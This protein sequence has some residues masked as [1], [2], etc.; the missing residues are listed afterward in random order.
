MEGERLAR[1]SANSY[2]FQPTSKPA[3]GRAVRTVYGTAHELRGAFG[4]VTAR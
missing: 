3:A 2:T 4:S 1:F